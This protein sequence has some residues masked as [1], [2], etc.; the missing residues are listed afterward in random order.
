MP[1][2]AVR[3]LLDITW[4]EF[5][6]IL[7]SVRPD[8]ASHPEQ[9]LHGSPWDFVHALVPPEMQQLAFRELA[10]KCIHRVKRDVHDGVDAEDAWLVL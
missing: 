9:V 1:V 4:T 7:C 6:T 8:I 10:L 5:R 3:R 2:C